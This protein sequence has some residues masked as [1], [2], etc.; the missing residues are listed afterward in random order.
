M[1][2]STPPLLNEGGKELRASG[3]ING[4]GLTERG[5]RERRKKLGK[6]T[7]LNKIALEWG[8]LTFFR[9]LN[10]FLGN[11]TL[12]KSRCVVS[13]SYLTPEET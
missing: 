4:K 9:A 6:K 5:R 3:R 1:I 12:H 13:P 10:L 2:R 7:E 11:T 8:L